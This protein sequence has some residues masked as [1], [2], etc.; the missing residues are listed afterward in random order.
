[1]NPTCTTCGAEMK[2]IPAGVS[3]AIGKPYNAFYACPNK[4]PKPSNNPS[5]SSNYAKAKM[6]GDQFESVMEKKAEMIEEAQDRK[7]KAI[8]IAGAKSGAALILA[9]MIQNGGSPH[10]IDEWQPEYKR[11][12]D[13]IYNFTPEQLPPF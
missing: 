5:F 11:I 12:A 10:L 1:M 9:A 6:Q 4:C 2:H 7:E 8:Q 13:W 3:R